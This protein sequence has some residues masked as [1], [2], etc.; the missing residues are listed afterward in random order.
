M[1]KSESLASKLD[2]QIAPELVGKVLAGRYEVASV[3]GLGSMAAVYLVHHVTIRKRM[4]AKVLHPSLLQI[5]EMLARF[6]REALVAGHLE[7]PNVAAAHDFGRTD[8]GRL[9]FVLEYIEGRELRALLQ[10]GPVSVARTI[11]IARQIASVL[12]MAHSFHIVHRDLKPENIMLTQRAG[13][14]DFVKILDF[15][16][17]KVPVDMRMKT[18]ISAVPGTVSP[19]LTKIGALYGTPGYLAPEQATSEAVDGR[20]DLYALGSIL[21]EM[22][23]GRTPFDGNTVLEIIDEH[24]Q[25]PLPPMRQRAPLIMIPEPVEALVRRLLAKRPEDRFADPRAL[26]AALEPLAVTYPLMAP[27][28]AE[29][30]PTGDSLIMTVIP[31]AAPPPPSPAARKGTIVAMPLPGGS[32]W[33][34]LGLLHATLPTPL[35]KIPLALLLVSFSM[36]ILGLI[37]LPWLLR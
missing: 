1:P 22:L 30:A 19:Q 4:A 25:K 9:F 26:L 14:P 16:L 27:A 7:H 23:T 17:A 13:Q 10:Q 3:L 28:S 37:A 8:D 35:S 15:G 2:F 33:A 6:E 20:C 34:Q 24:L 12:E 11:H 31:G 36:F 29:A 21:Y 32:F 18:S 5:P